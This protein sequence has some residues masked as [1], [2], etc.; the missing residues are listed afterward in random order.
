MEMLASSAVMMAFAIG[1]FSALSL[2]L[3]TLTSFVWKPDQRVIAA[4]MA[5][6]AGALLAA[7]TIDLVA[8]G[9][10]HGHFNYLGLGFIGG[11]L[12]FILLDN[13]VGN[14]GGYRRKISTTIYHR[15]AQ[16]SR[17]LSKILEDMGRTDVFKDLTQEDIEL[18]AQDVQTRFC[19][20]GT[21]IF[22][23]GDPANS[24]Y[25]VVKGE[26]ELFDPQENMKKFLEM[27][28]GDAFG[29]LSLLTGSPHTKVARAAEDTWLTVIS[30]VTLRHLLHASENYQESVLKWLDTEEVH[31]YLIEQHHM[32]EEDFQDW[33]ADAKESLM[34]E[35]LIPDAIEVRRETEA[36]QNFAPSLERIPW[37]EDMGAEE[38]DAISSFLVYKEY[39]EGEALFKQ[40]VPANYLYFIRY[41]D[42]LMS[43]EEN[44]SSYHHHEAGDAVGS[45]AFLCGLRHTVT[46]RVQKDCGVWVL[47]R[48]DLKRLMKLHPEFRLRLLNYLE[49]P[50]ISD[51]QQKRYNLNQGKVLAW[52]DQA[53]NSVKRGELPPSLLEMGIES[54]NPHGA[55]LAIW[56]GIMLDGIPE[57][58][59]I[60]AN[61]IHGPISVSLV[62]GL[63]LSNYPEALSSSHGMR[64]EGMSRMKIL[65]MWTSIMIFT[66]I[67]AAL[68]NIFMQQ[69][70]PH[71][72]AIIEGVAAG[73]M[74]TMIAQTMLPEAYHKGGS[75]TGFATMM[76]F[77]ITIFL[78][79]LGE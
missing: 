37:L 68:G 20:K 16:N 50:M 56:L 55:A 45:R 1:L 42:V 19:A 65:M 33:L 67:G 17:Y 43:D 9:L 3:G 71:T 14:Y 60:G 57:S 13:V 72:F 48:N 6:G 30:E 73:A 12:L 66:G 61:M 47:K 40:G 49:E 35:G 58:L 70:E 31:A 25:V 27:K 5:F 11:S 69:A 7:L 26:V 29:R 62:A 75:V 74:L 53:R 76:G 22:T 39:K 21:L 36:F 78:K 28:A 59:V 32:S 4:L 54:T 46:A 23:P 8:P 63:F 51:Y 24:L 34:E 64:E 38:A 10:E 79:T 52:T 18:V 41:G 44:K 77:L 2:P 15:N